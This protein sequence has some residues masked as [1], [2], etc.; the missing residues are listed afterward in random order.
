MGLVKA[1]AGATGGQLADQW[2]EF[3]YCEALDIYTLGAKGQKRVSD[4]NR[5]SNIRSSDNIISN[6]SLVAVNNGQC[7]LIVEQGKVVDICAEPGEYVYDASS[8]PSILFG[9]LGKGIKNSFNAIGK[10]FTLG[11]DTGKD[12]RVYFFN[13]KEL[14]SNKYGTISPIPFRVVDSNIGL[15]IDISLRCNGEYSFK[16][17]DPV[18]FYTN[19]TGNFE[20]RYG[21]GVI[22]SQLKTELL[23][24]LQPA[25]AKLSSQGI[26]YSAIPAHTKELSKVLNDELSSLWRDLRG[27]EIVSIAVSAISAPE[28]DQQLIKELQ[29]AAVMRDPTMAA[30]AMVGAQ[31]DAMRAAAGNEGGSLMGFMGLGMAQQAGGANVQSLFELGQQQAAAA[32]PVDGWTCSC[33]ATGNL[34]KF[35]GD[36]GKPRPENDS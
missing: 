10:R 6:G 20:D 7:M 30:A 3:F 18:L 15:D 19:V 26:R 36:C 16:I 24:A 4:Q 34:S 1:L 32:P 8:E 28:K 17:V 35:C 22:D 29:K 21:R 31:A 33:G 9:G 23:S 13:T 5:S 27:L 2:R 14:L 11:G 25:F 12:Q